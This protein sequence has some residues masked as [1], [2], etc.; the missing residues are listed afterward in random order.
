MEKVHAT[1][2][3]CTLDD[4]L[5]ERKKEMDVSKSKPFVCPIEGCDKRYKNP[6]GLKYHL[7]HGHEDLSLENYAFLTEDNEIKE[8]EF[9]TDP[10]KRSLTC[11]DI[12]SKSNKNMNPHQSSTSIPSNQ[13]SLRFTM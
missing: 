1:F 11:S 10:M 3:G 7:I 12:P 2:E 4:L 6:N 8:E 9:Q 5:A 13:S